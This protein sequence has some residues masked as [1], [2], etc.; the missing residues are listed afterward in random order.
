MQQ[1]DLIFTTT[2]DDLKLPG[3]YYPVDQKDICALFIH[4][5]SGFFLENY[6]H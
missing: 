2:D 4:G 1:M 6:L 5:M 3:L